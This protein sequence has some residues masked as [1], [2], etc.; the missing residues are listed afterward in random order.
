MPT[1]KEKDSRHVTF[2]ADNGTTTNKLF[3]FKVNDCADAIRCLKYFAVRDY[4]IRIA[5]YKTAAEQTQIASRGQIF[6][7]TTSG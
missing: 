7:L 4:Y 2:Y 6:E 1:S 3:D 5:W